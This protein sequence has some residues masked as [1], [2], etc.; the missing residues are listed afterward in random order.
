[1]RLASVE[2][3]CAA[4]LSAALIGPGCAP[5][6][7]GTSHRDRADQLAASGQYVAAIAEYRAHL[8]SRLAAAPRPESEN[9][10][11][12]YLDIGDMYLQLGKPAGAVKYYDLA[13]KKGV[14]VE[15]VNDR[16]RHVASWYEEQGRLREAIEHLKKYSER[17]PVLFGL[18]LDRIAKEIVER[19]EESERE[20]AAGP[21]EAPPTEDGHVG[22]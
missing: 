8:R 1:V 9:P 16:L 11:F 2:R 13:G 18:M 12:Y 4:L 5:S 20:Q 21:H 19:E 15:Y 6:S 10:Y 3:L 22:H 14:G 7:P 17:D